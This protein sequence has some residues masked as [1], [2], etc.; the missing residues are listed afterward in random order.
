M[1]ERPG[2]LTIGTVARRAGMNASRIRYYEAIGVLP[3]ADR[4]A[5]KRRYSEQVLR[6]LAIVDAAQR[7]G[8]TLEEIR[9]LF[10]SRDRLAHERLR[11]LAFLKLPEIDALIAQATTVRRLL[12][13]CS[14]C[15]C[16][17]IDMCRMFTGRA[18]PQRRAAPI[19]L[20][21][22]EHSIGNGAA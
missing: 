3:E 6:R 2:Q 21:A 1:G 5:G 20:Q 18:L 17:S 8:F 11:E 9:E 15:S 7:V 22:P 16:E 13:I 10:G 19:S 12:E 4:V 14:T